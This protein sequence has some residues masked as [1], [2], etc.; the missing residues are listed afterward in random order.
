[1]KIKLI[2]CEGLRDSRFVQAV[3][4]FY[5]E[6]RPVTDDERKKVEKRLEELIK[7]LL[8]RIEGIYGKNDEYVIV[9]NMQSKFKKLLSDLS[10]LEAYRDLEL[11][12]D[13]KLIFVSDCEYYEL[14]KYFQSCLI[15]NNRIEDFIMNLVHDLGV[16]I[17]IELANDLLK[18]C[19]KYNNEIDEEK[20]RVQ[21]YHLILSAGKCDKVMFVKLFKLIESMK[22]EKPKEISE[23]INLLST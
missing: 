18:L 16:E 5:T 17:D 23:L 13:V 2:L 19:Q 7:N 9:L 15:F 3:L 8:G 1:M 12:E 10:L 6:F 20:F 4:D 11:E 22:L 14:N 21:L